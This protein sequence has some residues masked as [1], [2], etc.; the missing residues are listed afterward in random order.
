[1]PQKKREKVVLPEGTQVPDHIAIIPDGNR[2][3]ARARGLSAIEGHRK[4][5]EALAKVLEASRDLNIHTVTFWGLSTEN[6]LERE[7]E[8][9]KFLLG[10]ISA[11]LDRHLEDAKKKGVRVIHLGHKDRL[12]K[13]LIKKIDRI[14]KET[15]Q[16]TE[17]V[18]N[19][20]LDYGGQD[21]IVRAVQKI[22]KSGAQ[23]NRID[24]KFIDGFMDTANQPYPYPDLIIRTSGEQ[25]T[26]GLLLWQSNYAE[27]YWELDHFPDF[28]PEKLRAAI[29][30]YSRRRRRFGGNDSQEH[31]KFDPKVVAKL[32]L[33]WRHALAIGEGERFRDLVVRYVREHYGLSREL[34]KT[35]GKNLAQALV[36]GRAEKWE[37][38]KSALEGLYGI[39]R[40]TL[41]L[42]L[43]PRFVATLEVDLWR[44]NG[45]AERTEQGQEIEGKLRQLYAET[46]RVSDLQATKAAHLSALATAERDI[47]GKSEGSEAQRHWEKAGWYTE[48]AYEALKERVA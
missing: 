35:A 30:D 25:R 13:W 16:N 44:S 38:A 47:A 31:L 42:A 26:S 33:A 24:G 34:A 22:V 39:L 17:H 18:F 3:W 43:E 48:K 23:A 21:E 5:A 40:K 12:P 46:F 4:G 41:G 29:L 36:F 28:T 37:A 1:M 2:R 8:E 11:G 7:A 27:T 20:A 45:S 15:L 10:T 14:E 9:R 6:W 32:E 19:I